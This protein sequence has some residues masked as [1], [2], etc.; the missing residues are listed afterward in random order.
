MNKLSKIGLS[1]LCGSLAAISA[2]NAGEITVSGGATIT[3]T[4]NSAA[5]TGNPLGMASSLTFAGSGELDGGQAI[6]LTIANDDQ[7]AYSSAG[8]SLTTNSLGTFKLSQ[9]EG[10]NGIDAY[11]DK[12]PTA[13]EEV[14]GTGLGIGQDQIGGLGGSTSVQWTSP[15]IMGSTIKLA[16]A[17]KNDGVKVNDKATS[18]GADGTKGD[19]YDIVLDLNPPTGDL[20]GVNLFGGYHTTDMG[21]GQQ[22]GINTETANDREEGT[23]GLILTVGPVTAGYQRSIEHTG[24]TAAASVDA[25]ANTNWGLAFNVN[26]NLSI[27]YGEYESKKHFVSSNDAPARFLSADSFQIAYTMGGASIRLMEQQVT[28]QTYSTAAT[29][30][31]DATIISLG[32]AF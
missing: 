11:D 19:A 25:Y 2:A 12:A 24:L 23:V 32:L 9:G 31:F 28:D 17:P 18:G 22:S 27:S 30:D 4:S 16:Y 15:S 6:G 7:N 20:I 29:A 10:T 3:H 14:T 8:I 21:G 5:E 13:W 1:A 26:D